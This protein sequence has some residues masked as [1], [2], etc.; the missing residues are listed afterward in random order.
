MMTQQQQ[1][2]AELRGAVKALDDRLTQVCEILANWST[3][4]RIAENNSADLGVPVDT[5]QK[6]Y[7]L[8]RNLAVEEFRVRMVIELFTLIKAHLRNTTYPRCLGKIC[9][10]LCAI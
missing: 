10:K 8:E 4:G 3:A 9:T 5:V 2:T 1:S 7:E 6:L